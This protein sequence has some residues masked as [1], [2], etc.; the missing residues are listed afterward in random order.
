MWTGTKCE[1]LAAKETGT[2]ERGKS[3]RMAVV[4]FSF[5]KARERDRGTSEKK[6]NGYFCGR[7]QLTVTQP[8][9]SLTTARKMERAKEGKVCKILHSGDRKDGEIERERDG[10]EGKQ[11][12]AISGGG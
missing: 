8:T 5:H 7:L 3:S 2:A 1:K 12:T 9:H 6:G 11:R 10:V 4:I